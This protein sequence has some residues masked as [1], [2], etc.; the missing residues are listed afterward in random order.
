MVDKKQRALT[1]LQNFC[2]VALNHA[3]AAKMARQVLDDIQELDRVHALEH[4]DEIVTTIGESLNKAMC[5]AI[6]AYDSS[7]FL[8]LASIATEA[9]AS[10]QDI[11]KAVYDVI[12]KHPI[13]EKYDCEFSNLTG[14]LL[15]EGAPN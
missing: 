15:P 1:A 7:H 10:E 8:N 9:G 12:D 2:R 14:A 4:P 13:M 5:A 11:G 6:A 3:N